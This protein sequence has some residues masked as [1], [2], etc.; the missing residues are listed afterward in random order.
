[1]LTQLRAV[2]RRVTVGRLMTLVVLATLWEALTRA[3][4]D[5]RDTIP[6]LSSTC[7]ALAHV[8]V[9]PLL[10]IA[11]GQTLRSTLV[12]LVLSVVIG[13]VLGM[14][15]ASR[16]AFVSSTRFVVDF[17]RT[18]P[19]L[20]VVPLFLLVFGPTPRM[21]ILLI[22]SVGVWPVLLQTI[23]G[24]RGVDA[25]LLQTARSFRLRRWR[26]AVFVIGPAAMPY[27]AA[28]IRIA[29]TLSLLLAIGTELIAGV[30]GLGQEI[31]LAQQ[32][33]DAPRMFAQILVT[34][35]VGAVLSLAIAAVEMRLLAWHYRPRGAGTP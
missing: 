4:P 30:P 17:C 32:A 22:L 16:Q 5:L 31:L 15:I 27:V 23:Y 26:R 3:N 12:G 20:A 8:V 33:G 10:W 21:E 1:L 18:V 6:T 34:G 9:D 28:G 11:L 2:D 25:E 19:P 14:L 24:V 29:A 35:A 13:I 7:V